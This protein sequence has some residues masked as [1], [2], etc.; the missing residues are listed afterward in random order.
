ML[1]K[2]YTTT[3]YTI[4]TNP[5]LSHPQ[6]PIRNPQSKGSPLQLRSQDLEIVTIRGLHQVEGRLAASQCDP[7][8]VPQLDAWLPVDGQ[9][10]V[11]VRALEDQVDDALAG[12]DHRTV[13]QHVRADR[14]QQ[15]R[16]HTR[17]NY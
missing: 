1:P 7:V 14:R 9:H 10:E 3:H 4:T 15:D 13:R 17:V 16:R 8:V 12:H 2:L 11:R 6:S 5:H